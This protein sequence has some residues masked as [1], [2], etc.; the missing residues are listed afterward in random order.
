MLAI[1]GKMIKSELLKLAPDSEKKFIE[2]FFAKR[3]A[4]MSMQSI[5]PSIAEMER[6]EFALR[7]EDA[8]RYFD[9][10]TLNIAGDESQIED[11]VILFVLPIEA[12][13]KYRQ[14]FPGEPYI[15]NYLRIL[16]ASYAEALSERGRGWH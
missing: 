11:A 3:L 13:H 1:Y 2:K 16:S 9:A 12:V 14:R 4:R 10:K 8:A 6:D 5:L 15:G 7:V